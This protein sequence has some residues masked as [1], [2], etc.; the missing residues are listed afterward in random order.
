MPEKIRERNDSSRHFRSYWPFPQLRSDRSSAGTK[1][2]A[3]EEIG[4]LFTH[5]RRRYEMT[6]ID[7]IINSCLIPPVG[8]SH[9]IHPGR[10]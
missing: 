8:G 2:A 4:S 3:V 6:I 1:Q 7:P 10:S 9:A 5:T